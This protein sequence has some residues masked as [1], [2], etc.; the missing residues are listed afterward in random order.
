M[1]D[2][3]SLHVVFFY[4]YIS[5]A[6]ACATYIVKKLDINLLITQQLLKPKYFTSTLQTWISRFRKWALAAFCFIG[7]LNSYSLINIYFPR[8]MHLLKAKWAFNEH[9]SQLW[10]MLSCSSLLHD[11]HNKNSFSFFTNLPFLTLRLK[12]FLDHII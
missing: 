2:W 5:V 1:L 10:L 6:V 12:Q 7:W 3:A 8:Y 9:L 11:K 4:T